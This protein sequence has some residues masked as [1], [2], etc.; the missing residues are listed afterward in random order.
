MEDFYNNEEHNDSPVD[1]EATL[2]TLLANSPHLFDFSGSPLASSGDGRFHSLSSSLQS[3]PTLTPTPT[4]QHTSNPSSSF[5]SPNHPPI[6]TTS[7]TMII[8]ANMT[9]PL[10]PTPSH[11]QSTLAPPQITLFPDSPGPFPNDHP[12]LSPN[13]S[14]N[15]S[16]SSLLN[17]AD[18]KRKRRR[19]DDNILCIQI[20]Y[21]F[22]SFILSLFFLSSSSFSM[23]KQKYNTR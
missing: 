8:S 12:N 13:A 5:I 7:T 21:L 23:T 16:D 11:I 18:A 3:A 9:N 22:L 14:N 19:K 17:P 6:P 15:V 10:L 2:S 20:L 1:V 4:L